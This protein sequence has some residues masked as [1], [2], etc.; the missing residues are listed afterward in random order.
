MD[1]KHVNFYIILVPRHQVT[2]LWH[3]I[4]FLISFF[5]LHI[6]K[7]WH[8]CTHA[9]ALSLL[10]SGFFANNTSMPLHQCA[11]SQ[12][13]AL[14]NF[15]LI[16]A[17]VAMPRN[18]GSHVTAP[19]LLFSNLFFNARFSPNSSRIDFLTYFCIW[20]EKQAITDQITWL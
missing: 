4:F 20:K 17:S 13:W 18:Q 3:W 8:Q 7:S 1:K 9:T 2:M 16:C 5:F 11:M 12:Q 15:V 14:L 6:F 19:R 10:T